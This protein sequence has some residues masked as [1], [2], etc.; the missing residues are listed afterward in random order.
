PLVTTLAH[1]SWAYWRLGRKAD[2][3]AVSRQSV[4]LARIQGSPET[5]C[6]ALAFAA[7]LQRFLGNT[8]SAVKHAQEVAKIASV[9]QL[10]LWQ[11]F[12]EM[13]LAWAQAVQG[14]D[15]ALGRLKRCARE[16]K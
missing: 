3:Q 14:D 9:Y 2:A 11:G 8:G 4:E 10:V 6:F 7:M 12:A 15:A 5:L 1:L 13:M 16:I